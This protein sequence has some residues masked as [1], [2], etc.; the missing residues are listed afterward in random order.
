MD[1]WRAIVLLDEVPVARVR[2]P[3]PGAASDGFRRAA[4]DRHA[5]ER[6]AHR[7]LLERMERRLGV[8]QRA[9]AR[10]TVSVVVCT[11]RRP[12]M[13]AGLLQAIG[14]LDPAPDEI[15]VVDNDPGELAVRGAALA[16]GVRYQRE[17]RRGL[18]HARTTGLEAARGDLVAFIDDDCVPSASWL[19]ALPELFDD[20]CVAAVTGPAFAHE[21]DSEA[22]L[23]F[24]D[25]GGFGRGFHRRVHEWTNLS[26]PGASRA[27]AGANMILRRSPA[28]SLEG[29]FPLEL[30]AGT[31]TR[32]GG[33]LYALYRLLATGHRVVYDPGTYVLHR[34]R[35]D[36]ESMH[37]T[38]RGYGTGIA[39]AVTK[40]LVE[41]RDLSALG[42][43][44]WLVE[45]WVRARRAPRGGVQRAIARDYVVGALRGPRA[46]RASRASAV[47]GGRLAAPGD[48]PPTAS[49]EPSA[50]HRRAS[51][52]AEL[53]VIVTTHHRPRALE[54]CLD[55]LRRQADGTPPF[56]LIVAQRCAGPATGD[57]WRAC[58]RDG[59][60]GHSRCAQRG[61]C[62]RARAGAALPR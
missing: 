9:P 28:L 21:L 60:G 17:A 24:E 61:R 6:R 59:R 31:P 41:Q 22:K 2:L 36:M 44:W 8:P 26:P 20:P 25:T 43:L 45:Q 56:E 5:D 15:V 42:A 4:V 54:R 1:E 38:F 47:R 13:L 37:E 62:G 53:S 12:L 29:L 55:T 34:H 19:R 50:G 23:A 40:M 58:D 48:V 49:R 27:G 14:R 11:H 16:A 39:A 51:S 32:S 57:G 33:D 7:D 30:D 46:W 3:D 52:A 18:D 10:L 35:P